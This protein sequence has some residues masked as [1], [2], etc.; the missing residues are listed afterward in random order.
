M[1]GGISER[2]ART[3]RQILDAALALPEM[4]EQFEPMRMG[5]RVSDLRETRKNL[6]FGPVLDMASDLTISRRTD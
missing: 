5:K 6:L 2:E 1:S 4:F 3:G